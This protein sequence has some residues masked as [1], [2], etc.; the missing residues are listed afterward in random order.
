VPD[1]TGALEVVTSEV[2]NAASSPVTINPSNGFVGGLTSA[3]GGQGAYKI[4]LQDPYVR[5]LSVAVTEVDTA[6]SGNP[7]VGI[8]L[9]DNVNDQNAPSLTIGFDS[10]PITSA[11]K[12]VLLS[13]TLAN[14]T[15]L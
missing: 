9:V 8:V 3:I 11:T 6:P 4:D 15:A 13:V 10:A 14:S 5:L 12:T 2:I 1:G 7:L